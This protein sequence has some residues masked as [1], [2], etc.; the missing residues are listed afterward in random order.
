MSTLFVTGGRSEASR[1]LVDAALAG[2]VQT[3]VQPTVTFLEGVGDVPDILRSAVAAE[4][5]TERFARAGRRGIVVRLGL[6]D[7]PGTGHD[8]PVPGM[9]ATVHV[10]DAADAMLATLAAPSGTYNVCRDGERVANR[11]LKAVTHW[12]PKR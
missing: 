4:E 3:Y 9:G 11:R 8:E 5:E 1:V 6:L 10:A 2:A 12:R 7:G